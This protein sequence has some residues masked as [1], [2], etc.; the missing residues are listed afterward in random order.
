MGNIFYQCGWIIKRNDPRFTIELIASKSEALE[1]SVRAKSLLTMES[2]LIAIVLLFKCGSYKQIG[3]LRTHLEQLIE[4]R[5]WSEV[6]A[7]DFL[8]AG[9]LHPVCGRSDFAQK[10]RQIAVRNQVLLDSTRS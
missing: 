10:L 5:D 3:K 9:A 1:C 4:C 6:K 8:E 7:E 2:G